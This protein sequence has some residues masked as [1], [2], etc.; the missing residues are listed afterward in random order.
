[1]KQ[2]YDNQIEIPMSPYKVFDLLD[3]NMWSL[4]SSYQRFKIRK[5]VHG[6]ASR[7]TQQFSA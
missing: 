6:P 3:A 5:H 2:L 1:M 7:G 4:P